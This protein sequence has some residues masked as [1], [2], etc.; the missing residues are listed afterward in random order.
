MSVQLMSVLILSVIAILVLAIIRK[1]RRRRG[2]SSS[3]EV[4]V[5][6]LNY[7]TNEADLKRH[8][9]QYGK[10][11]EIKIIKNNRTGRSKGYAFIRYANGN[12]AEQALSSHGKE[13]NTRALVVRIAKSHARD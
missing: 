9:S 11:N 13:F 4:Y 2:D 12:E 7:Q 3:H 5:G 8:F 1:S 6:N 10:I